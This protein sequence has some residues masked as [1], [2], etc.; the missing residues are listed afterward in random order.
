MAAGP[1]ERGAVLRGE[2][3]QRPDDVEQVLYL[4]LG[5]IPHV[6]ITMGVLSRRP[7]M[8]LNALREVQIETLAPR[9]EHLPRNI[10]DDRMLD[11]ISRRIGS[12]QQRP[13]ALGA[14]SIKTSL[15]EGGIPEGSIEI[16]RKPGSQL[17]RDRVRKYTVAI[18][19]QPVRQNFDGFSPRSIR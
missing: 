16:I 8:N 3:A 6:L 15:T 1:H 2:R 12:G 19:Q 5:A 10:K 4:A 17:R 13:E 18:M 11:K 7:G 9:S 14:R